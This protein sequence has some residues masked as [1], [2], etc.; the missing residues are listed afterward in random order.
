MDACLTQI[1][2]P[3]GA[4][5]GQGWGERQFG[6]TAPGFPSGSDSEESAFNAGQALSVSRLG[7]SP[8]A[9]NGNP[10]QHSCL[11]NLMNRGAWGATVHRVSNSWTQLRDSHFYFQ[12]IP[13]AKHLSIERLLFVFVFFP[14]PLVF[15]FC[16]ECR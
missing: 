6:E 13:P 10:L 12:K 11:R 4:D 14:T 15:S 9:R 5:K 7:R 8:G 2:R 16:P 1:A 3:M